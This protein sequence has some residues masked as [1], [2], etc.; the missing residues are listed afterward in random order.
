MARVLRGQDN[1]HNIYNDLST[2]MSLVQQSVHT[3]E[4]LGMGKTA[5]GKAIPQGEGLVAATS[6]MDTGFGYTRC[7][8]GQAAVY[9]C[10]SW[11]IMAAASSS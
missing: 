9:I 11:A 5:S 2:A 8:R 7:R 3:Q 10:F 1:L 6:V 4:Q